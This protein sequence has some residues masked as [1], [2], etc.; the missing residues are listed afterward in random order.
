MQATNSAPCSGGITQYAILRLV[1][2]NCP[3][4]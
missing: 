3:D 4:N 1:I 2:P